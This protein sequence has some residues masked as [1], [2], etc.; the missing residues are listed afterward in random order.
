METE[1]EELK[2]R[3]SI[4]RQCADLIDKI[5][6]TEDEKEREELWIR[7]YVKMTKNAEAI[8]VFDQ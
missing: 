5:A 2:K 7:L 3:A 4:F 6:E 1:K 8:K